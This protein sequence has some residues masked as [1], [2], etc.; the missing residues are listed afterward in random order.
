M[1]KHL[2]QRFQPVQTID[3]EE[4]T[5][6]AGV[7]SLNEACALITCNSGD[8]IML[9][10]PIYSPFAKDLVMRTGYVGSF[11]CPDPVDLMTR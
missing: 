3:P 6:T 11:R 8:S 2:N 9:G 1:T 5:F 4:I 10:T 7:T